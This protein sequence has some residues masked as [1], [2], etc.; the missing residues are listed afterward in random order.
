MEENLGKKSMSNREH[1]RP[2]KIAHISI[3]SV[4]HLA[5]ESHVANLV[6]VGNIW[7]D[8]MLTLASCVLFLVFRLFSLLD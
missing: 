7:D 2:A 4:F 1:F 6:V 8:Q 5:I 3:H